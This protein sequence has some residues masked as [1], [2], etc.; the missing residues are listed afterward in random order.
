M[1]TSTPKPEVLEALRA[2]TLSEDGLT[3]TLAGE[4]DRKVYQATAKTIEI[5]GGKWSKK[6]KAHEFS[7]DFRPQLTPSRSARGLGQDP[8]PHSGRCPGSCP[9]DLGKPHV[10]K[11]TNPTSRR[12][13][14]QRRD[15]GK[16][17]F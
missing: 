17:H 5:Y 14:T 15:V 13:Q 16:P 9:S 2:A 4:L 3:L 6:A 12:G 7:T 1:T 8:L 10:Q 11:W